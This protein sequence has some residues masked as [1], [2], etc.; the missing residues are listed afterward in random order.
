VQARAE[1]AGRDPALRAAF[2]VAV[3]RALAPLP[4]LV[5]YA[6]PLLRD[7]GVLAAP[8][9]S[10]A[11]VEL[12]AAAGAIASLGGVALQPVPLSLPPDALPQLVLFVRREGALDD[13]YPRRAG[14][15][16]KRPLS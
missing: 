12:E 11:T 14:I 7:G 8:K 2:D 5:E 4:V 3:A 6:L 16:S 13:R 9:G 1:D 15:P 10:R